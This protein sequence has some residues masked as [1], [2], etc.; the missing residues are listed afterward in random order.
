MREIELTARY[1]QDYKKAKKSEKLRNH[2]SKTLPSVIESLQNDIPLAPKFCDHALK[3]KN[4]GKRECHITPDF[5]LIYAKSNGVV[6]LLEL[7]RLGSHSE[8]F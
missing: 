7:H 1:R 4:N 5:L 6:Q 8:V 2:L 3:G